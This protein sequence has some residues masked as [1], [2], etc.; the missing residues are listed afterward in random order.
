MKS[1]SFAFLTALSL[2]LSTFS[3]DAFAVCKGGMPNGKC[4]PPD[5]D[6]ACD[7]CLAACSGECTPENPPMCTL[8]D[9]CTC[10]DCW[11][12]PACTD[13]ELKNCDDDGDCNF[14]LEGCCCAD[15]ASL[16]NCSDFNG[17]CSQGTGGAGGTGGSGGT[18]GGSGGATGGGGTGGTVNP[19][20]GGDCG[21]VAA[22]FE[23]S[24][25]GSALALI[26]FGLVA[27]R[28]RKTKRE[29]AAKS[30]D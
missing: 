18:A 9:A 30:S 4:E 28:R 22:G 29:G 24:A 2:A 26:G 14:F 23:N 19:V 16:S 5:D 25:G 15:C 17:T 27:F 11:A 13:P 8:E 20:K 3:L 7:D 1:S 21:C 6:C 12:D 10:S